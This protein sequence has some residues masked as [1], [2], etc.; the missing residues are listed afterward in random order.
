MNFGLCAAVRSCAVLL[1]LLL[2]TSGTV[3]AQADDP[4]LEGRLLRSSA[5][6]ESQG[7]LAEA[8]SILRDLM[9]QRPTSSGGLF[10]LERVL[11]SRGRIG[12]VLPMAIAY[13]DAEPAAA[14]P[15]VLMLR[16]YSELG[17][18]GDLVDAAELWIEE[19]GMSAEPYR[20]VSRV[21][22]RVFGPQRAFA[23]LNDGREVLEQ[24]SLFAMEMGDLLRELGRVEEAVFEWARVIDDDGAQVSAVM[25]R[26]TEIE[27][28]RADMVR[29]LVAQLAS[30]PTTVARQRVATRIAVEAGLIEEALELAGDVAQTLEGQARRGFLTALAR[31]AEEVGGAADLTLWTYMALQ[32]TATDAA[33]VRALD[34]RIADAA[35]VA[36]DTAMALAAQGSIAEGLPV[37]SGE[38][39]RALAEVLRLEIS[40]GVPDAR[41]SLDR[42]R[43]EYPDATETDELVVTL[44]VRLEEEG[45]GM[46]ARSLLSGVDGP[47][48]LLE[49]GFLYLASAEVVP[50]RMNLREAIPGLPPTSA[51]DLI[52]LLSLLD[53]LQGESLAVVMSSSVLAHRGRIAA[54]VQEVQTMIDQLP[55]ADRP[56]LLAHGA[57]LADEGEL[58]TD[59]AALRALIVADYPDA[60]ETPEATLELARFRGATVEGVEEA[61]QLLEDLI[62]SMPENA[63][64]PMARRELQKLKAGRGS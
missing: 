59:A 48:S 32:G 57:R 11:R 9:A 64:V 20:E 42:F 62:L 17:A 21:F 36:G 60:A 55:R 45:D 37:G 44:A 13:R 15:R 25:R 43:V 52:S 22:E 5:S 19:S 31:Q 54:A 35:L 8:E 27:E 3:L 47:K 1:G 50:A 39:R 18:Q 28:D 34:H 12:D 10:A 2:G 38:R 24:P 33:E 26:V 4:L 58:I 61:V 7:N 29:P 56:L 30:A 41:A 63:M 53:E 14:A 23:V 40:R 51:T 49:R 46:G 6:Q 16:V